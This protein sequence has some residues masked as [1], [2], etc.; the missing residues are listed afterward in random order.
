MSLRRENGNWVVR[1]E[2][3][4]RARIAYARIVNDR[5]VYTVD[6]L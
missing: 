1:G 3:S 6:H 5:L 4:E 2:G